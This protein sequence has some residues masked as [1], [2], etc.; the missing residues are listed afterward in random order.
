VQPAWNK[1]K[2]KRMTDTVI[3][4]KFSSKQMSPAIMIENDKQTKH[5]G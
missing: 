1:E 4:N 5:Y 3:I 2:K